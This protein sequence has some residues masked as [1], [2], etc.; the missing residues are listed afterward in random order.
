MLVI[1]IAAMHCGGAPVRAADDALLD[2]SAK[3]A[4]KKDAPKSGG[5]DLLDDSAPAPKAKPKPVEHP[6][7]EIK[8]THI[9]AESN[10]K[11][12]I[13]PPEEIEHKPEVP[14]GFLLVP[15]DPG[16]FKSDPDY[17]GKDYDPKAQL[18]I[19]GAKHMNPN[20]RP[21]VELGRELYQY[22]PFQQQPEWLGK[23][24]PLD[25][26]LLVF[27]DYRTAVAYNDNGAKEQGTWAH[28]LNL[29][30]DGRITATERVHAFFRP[31]DR[32]G[33]FTR[34]D[35]SGDNHEFDPEIDGNADALFFEGDA[36]AIIGGLTN[37][38]SKFDMPIA[39]GLIP[40]LFQNGI[41]VQDAFQGFAF[42][43]P[44]R[45][46]RALDISNFDITFFAGFDKVTTGALPGKDHTARIYGVTGFFETLGGYIEAGY[47][48][49]E[50]DNGDGFDYHN[51]TI[52]FT[53]RYFGWLSNSVRFIGNAGQHPH[54]GLTQTA[55]G[56]L[57]LFENSLITDAPSNFVPYFNFFVGFDRPQPLAR[58]AGAGGVLVN[59]GINFESDGLTGYP[60]LDATANN[61]WGGAL[62]VNLLGQNFENQLVLEFAFVQA[63][64][65]NKTR[66]APGDQYAV[67]LR[68][69]HPISNAVILRFDT[70]YGWREEADPVAGVRFEI[71][72]KF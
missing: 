30:V 25:P 67:G 31:L 9:G 55:D 16:V 57:L 34:L 58:D 8:G 41:W 49:T 51:F 69:Q 46:S 59:T 50:D 66:N 24:N 53:H 28:R 60:T 14:E 22:G 4:P 10:A 62:G 17:S 61:T 1:I 29:D 42:T 56:V 18:D 44:A 71:R 32:N 27:G 65:D 64:D 12:R 48:Y 33:Q 39:A 43:I 19:Y 68:Y 13:V 35:F 5:D 3:P 63:F 15:H 40:L 37:T 20:Q 21:L 70:M 38:E 11:P 45:N 6:T 52:A 36:G 54:R 26:Q 47:G 23:T 7:Q 2:D 72:Y